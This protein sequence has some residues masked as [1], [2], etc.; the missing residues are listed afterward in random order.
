MC[1][2]VCVLRISVTLYLISGNK[3]AF[4]NFL[5]RKVRSVLKV[6]KVQELQVKIR[7]VFQELQ[8]KIREVFQELQ[9]KIP[10]TLEVDPQYI[11]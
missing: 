7:E 3:S 9:V 4:L 5:V 8:V 2:A 11:I 1:Y 10:A 6:H